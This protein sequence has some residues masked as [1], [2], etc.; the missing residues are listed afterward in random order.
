MR[1]IPLTRGYVAIVDDEDY[2][3][4]MAE[5]PWCYCN[6]YAVRGRGNIK[7]H[8]LI[9]GLTAGDG[10]QADHINRNK[11]DNRRCNLRLCTASQNHANMSIFRN[12]T[13]GYKGVT[14]LRSHGK[15]RAKI[16]V[17]GR[18]IFL[19]YFDN[20]ID[21][22]C[23]YDK[24]ARFHFGEFA[25]TNFQGEDNDLSDRNGTA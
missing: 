20:P 18:Y 5:G 8:R 2:E 14:F 19:G 16:K 17:R 22:A 4:L 13:T 6:G 15:Y 1:E 21:A 11:L 25:N 7:M 12:N 23:A 24:A 9:L 3:W 10:K